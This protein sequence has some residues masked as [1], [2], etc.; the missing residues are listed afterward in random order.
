M[1]EKKIVGKCSGKKDIKH[2]D[3]CNGDLMIDGVGRYQIP[4]GFGFRDGKFCIDSVRYQI[5]SGC[6]L[7]CGRDGYF[8]RVDITPKIITKRPAK[9]QAKNS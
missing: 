4:H 7:E 5:F 6:C 9:F 8:I 3:G 2:L 1:S